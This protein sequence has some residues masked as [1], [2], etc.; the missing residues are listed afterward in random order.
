MEINTIKTFLGYYER[1]R[2]RTNLLIKVISPEYLDFSYKTEKFTVAD[3]IR[4]IAATE[5]YLFAEIIAGGQC[6]YRGCGKEL[7]DGYD[8]VMKY[9]SDMHRESLVIF[10]NLCDEDLNRKCSLP[11]GEKIVVWKWLRAMVEHE[12]H[13]RAQLYIYLN[14]LNVKTPPIFGL[15]SEELQ[16]KSIKSN[17][18]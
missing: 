8:G 11:A 16:V 9:F 3:Q 15:T 5:R 4:H 6:A 1:V 13:H 18:L 7:A 10:S 17:S 12:I 14:M 2:E